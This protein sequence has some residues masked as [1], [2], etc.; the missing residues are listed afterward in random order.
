MENIHGISIDLTVKD[1]KFG[2]L[3]ILGAAFKTRRSDSRTDWQVVA[4]CECGNIKCY[5][6]RNLVTG[7]TTSCGCVQKKRASMANTTHGKRKSH[8]YAVWNAMLARCQN[9]KNKSYKNYGGRGI[10]VCDRWKS[11]ENFYSDMGDRPSEQH[12]IDRIDNNKDYCPENCRWVTRNV[13]ATNKRNNRYLE[14][15]GKTQTVSQW[16]KE[17]GMGAATLKSRLLLGWSV[18]KALTVPVRPVR[19]AKGK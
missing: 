2:K 16:A 4:S 19:K 18:E 10:S 13:Q 7:M 15:N 11:F 9:L 8:L 1:S 3:Q 6:L 14:Y 12:T 17:F 5:Y